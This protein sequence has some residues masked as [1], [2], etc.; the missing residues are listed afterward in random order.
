MKISRRI[1]YFLLLSIILCSETA[2]AQSSYIL[3]SLKRN[4]RTAMHDTARIS[5][6]CK[7]ANVYAVYEHKDSIARR[8]AEEALQTAKQLQNRNEDLNTAYYQALALNML[9]ISFRYT[10]HDLRPLA[11]QYFRLA[12]QQTKS[13]HDPR[14]ALQT[15]ALI[16]QSWFT[17][18]RFRIDDHSNKDR[19]LEQL[20]HDVRILLESQQAIAE[21]LNSNALRGQVLLCR[22]FILTPDI[23]QKTVLALQAARLYEQSSDMEGLASILSFVGFFSQIISDDARAMHAYKRVVQIAHENN[24]PRSLGIAY[25]AIGD[26]YAKLIDTNKAL[27]YYHRAEPFVEKYDVKTNRIELLQQIGTVYVQ[28]G[29]HE[30]A[31]VY[32]EKALTLNNDAGYGLHIIFLSGQLYRQMNKLE[33]SLRELKRGR[34]IAEQGSANKPKA[35]FCFEL[36][37]THQALAKALDTTNGRRALYSQH[38]DTAFAYARRYLALV[39]AGTPSAPT[40][41]QLLAAY[42]LLYEICKK[43]GKRDS[44]LHYLE[45]TR[46]WEKSVFATSKALE[47]AAMDSRA[48]VDAAQAKVEALEVQ[49]RLQRA[50]GIAIAIALV[51]LAMSIVL[52]Y[53]RNNERRKAT[54][55]LENHNRLLSAQNKELENLSAEKTMLMGIVAHDLKNPIAAVRNLATLM[56]VESGDD[57]EAKDISRHIVRASN[58]MLDLV[59][60]LLDNNRLEEGAMSFYCVAIDLVP[61]LESIIQRYKTMAAEKKITLEFIAQQASHVALVDESAAEQVFDN[62]ISNAVK[63]SPLGKNIIVR[64]TA[65]ND[66]LRV[67]VQDEGPGISPEDMTK[68]FGKF[69][70]LSARP[71]GGEHSTGLGLSIVKKMVE[72]MNGTVWCESE[73]GKGA[74]FIVELPRSEENL[75][76]LFGKE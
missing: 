67:E 37:L 24:L 29:E 16:Q 20:R 14:R 12:L 22:A 38:L 44:T 32:L 8:I 2:F 15:Q 41:E 39:M 45:Q 56:H 6:L 61:S 55:L 21:R 26:I 58:Q 48:V 9:G 4:V 73:L 59:I 63:Y 23:S 57:A 27:E 54:V 75:K 28:R 33:V 52:L 31:H 34:T 43:S 3:D 74:T 60:K 25:R 64:L 10:Q 62:L 72:A 70:R 47:I 17:S 19:V 42:S 53:R 65:R 18:L 49:D 36:A 1:L 11:E 50:I 13:I 69:A 66:V 68:L 35:D 76:I 46:T 5:A 30:K 51:A 71:T 7:L 40:P